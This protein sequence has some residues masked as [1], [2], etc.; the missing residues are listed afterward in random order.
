MSNSSVTSKLVSIALTTFNGGKFLE[1]QLLSLLSQTYKNIEI[2]ISDDGSTDNTILIIEEY[3]KTHPEIVLIKNKLEKGINKNFENAINHCKGD[4]IA[5]CDQDDLW[6]PHKIETLVNNIDKAALI[7]HNSLFVDTNGI[8]L[9]STIADKMNCYSGD[10][11]KTFLLFNCVS[12]HSCMFIRDLV[13]IAL[14]IP[15]VKYFDWWLAFVAADNAGVKYIDE[16]LVHYRQHEKSKTDMLILKKSTI[17]KKEFI[18]YDEELVWYNSCAIIATKNKAFFQL[19]AKYYSQ[20]KTQ[21]LSLSLFILVRKNASALY[22]IR[23]RNNVIRFFESLKLLWGIKLKT[24]F[25]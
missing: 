5:L 4:Y 14:P 8:S 3:K 9:N 16:V 18:M 20:R 22:C 24:L 19:L 2:I 25:G 17:H 12:G 1:D 15:K 13:A 11:P 10:N 23:K 6:M 7:Y 21:W